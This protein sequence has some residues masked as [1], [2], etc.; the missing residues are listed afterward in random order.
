[1]SL[2]AA[3]DGSLWLE[4]MDDE[5]RAAF[6]LRDRLD[7]PVDEV[8]AVLERTHKPLSSRTIPPEARP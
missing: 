8:A 6:I 2:L 4:F 7:L 1:V 5:I 3:R